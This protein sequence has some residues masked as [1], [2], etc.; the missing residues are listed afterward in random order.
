MSVVL[1]NLAQCFPSFAGR[2]G[3]SGNNNNMCWDHKL[4]KAEAVRKQLAC[5]H[6]SDRERDVHIWLCR[7]EEPRTDH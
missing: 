2:G 5:F 1:Q 4:E 3:G 6:D 7:S